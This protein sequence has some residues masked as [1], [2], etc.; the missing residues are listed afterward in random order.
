MKISTFPIACLLLAFVA[1]PAS[2]EQ[3]DP[4]KGKLSAAGVTKRMTVTQIDQAT[5]EVVLRST[6]GEET[7]FLAGPEVR[8]LAQVETGDT[9]TIT[10]VE[11]VAVRVYPI[12]PDAKG[13]VEKTEVSRAPLGAKPYGMVSRHIEL[14]GQVDALDRETRGRSWA[15]RAEA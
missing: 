7:T 14:T 2:A 12:S 11:G 4:I 3:V 13:R 10:Y 8:N 1:F 9:V 5:R 6:D 15:A